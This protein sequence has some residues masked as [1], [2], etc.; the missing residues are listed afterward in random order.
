TLSEP[1]SSLGCGLPLE[2][3]SQIFRDLGGAR[4][5]GHQRG[6]VRQ[7]ITGAREV[8]H[9]QAR[10]RLV[11]LLFTFALARFGR[12]SIG[13]RSRGMLEAL[14]IGS[15][16]RVGRRER[17]GRLQEIFRAIERALCELPVEGRERPVEIFLQL[18]CGPFLT[19][20]LAQLA[21]LGRVGVDF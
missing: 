12:L 10:R 6:R 5:A 3:L 18:D 7:Q 21:Q 13:E 2:S 16:Q 14:P 11:Y 8:A 9:F 1:F 19:Y 4:M 17:C 15:W 20:T